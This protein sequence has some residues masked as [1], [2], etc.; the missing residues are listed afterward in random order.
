M[1]VKTILR[2]EKN[3]FVFI[4]MG[5]VLMLHSVPNQVC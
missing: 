4:L 2:Q 1:L 5:K 3:I